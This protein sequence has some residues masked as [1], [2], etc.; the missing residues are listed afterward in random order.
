MFDLKYYEMLSKSQNFFDEDKGNIM[1]RQY[2]HN[3]FSYKKG[4]R[5]DIWM[6][7]MNELPD[8]DPLKEKMLELYIKYG[9]TGISEISKILQE[10]VSRGTSK[11]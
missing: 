7:R 10:E 8:N 2:L 11:F 6:T 4:K 5:P 1:S 3:S 9:E